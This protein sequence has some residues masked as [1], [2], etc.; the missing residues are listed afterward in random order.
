VYEAGCFLR[1]LAE[2]Y[3]LT[4]KDAL[5]VKRQL[6]EA[7]QQRAYVLHKD[8]GKHAAAIRNLY[9]REEPALFAAIRA[10]DS[11][12]ARKILNRVLVAIFHHGGNKLEL[13]KGFLLEL[14][15]SM[16]RSAIQA[17][18]PPDQLFGDSF[19]T[20]SGLS[21]VQSLE[22]MADWTR[23]TL[24]QLIEVVPIAGETRGSDRVLKALEHMRHHAHR[25]LTLEETAEVAGLSVSR[26]CAVLKEE[27]GAS[28]STLLNRMRIDRSA[29]I[30]RKSDTPI[31]E[32]AYQC[33]FKNQSYFTRVFKR[34]RGCS[35]RAFRQQR[36]QRK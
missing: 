14:V 10:G 11:G 20:L 2:A 8:V 19:V 9:A 3:N 35:P 16:F 4:N 34:E 12:E 31:S 21:T 18:A 28:F 22:A 7:E 6:Y 13:L 5:A 17:G 26:F 25:P 15:A 30:L 33:G 32:V 27:T 29:V 1:K 36:S 23:R 24:D